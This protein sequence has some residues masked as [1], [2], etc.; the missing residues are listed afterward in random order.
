[1]PLLQFRGGGSLL[2]NLS[3]TQ[4]NPPPFV[5]ISPIL[6]AALLDW[7]TIIHHFAGFPTP[8]QLIV[9]Q[10]PNFLVY[11]D[12]CFLGC[13]GI[14]C[15]GLSD[16]PHVVWKFR[17]PPSVTSQIGKTL[18]INDLEMAGIVMGW[19]VLESIQDD[20][21]FK[22][23]GLFADN[24]SS[25]SWT[26]K[27]STTTSL[28]AARLLRLLALRQRARRTSSLLPIHIKGSENAMADVSSRAFKQGEYFH[29]ATNILSFFNSN[30]PLP[31]SRSWHEHK[32]PRKLSWRVISSLLG[33]QLSMES[34]TRLPKLGTS[35]GVTGAATQQN[36][37]QL[38]PL[39]T[40]PPLPR[41]S[42]LPV[43]LNGSGGALTDL[44]IRSK[45]SQLTKP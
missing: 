41:P 30:F 17:W 14:T 21:S 35:I 42:S 28:P 34:L 25:V 13:G 32:V 43:S 33:E 27:G 16:L 18:S 36:A 1:M 23:V 11:A 22:H 31:Q 24:T 38:P 2:S 6:K 3:R 19:L 12:A 9:P 37:A 5:T 8:V 7:R 10:P 15:L 20:L 40:S 26:Q 44:E 4:R 45:F 39:P 29:A